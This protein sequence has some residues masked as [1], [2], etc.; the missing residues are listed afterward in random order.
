LEE[1]RQTKSTWKL[2]ALVL[3]IGL[4]AGLLGGALGALIFIQP[5]PQGEPGEEGPQGPE[6]PQGIPGLD[7]M[8]SILQAIQTRNDTQIDTSGY[9]ETQWYNLSDFDPSMEITTSVQQNSRVFVEFSSTIE[10]DAEATIW[11]RIVVDNAFNS[12]VCMCSVGPPS[13]VRAYQ[14]VGHVEFLTD[15]LNSGTRTINAQFWIETGSTN[16]RI[17]HRTL[18]VMELASP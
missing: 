14:M 11:V 12:S 13:S 16:V 2:L 7:G 6:G 9:T 5:G 10:I 4:L 1:D 15:S 17:Q 18:T 8:D 3:V